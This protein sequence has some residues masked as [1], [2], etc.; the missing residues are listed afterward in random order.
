MIYQLNQ[1]STHLTKTTS[2]QITALEA[3]VVS[4]KKDMAK[5]DS[6]R[7]IEEKVDSLKGV[8]NSIQDSNLKIHNDICVV[9]KNIEKSDLRIKNTEMVQ[10][11]KKS[12]DSLKMF[13]EMTKSLKNI[14]IVKTN[15]PNK[16]TATTDNSIKIAEIPRRKRI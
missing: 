15:A 4:I 5:S 9:N 1:I 2:E 11:R 13:G 6:I 3:S 12:D 14:E 16:E 10:L 8:V 7:K